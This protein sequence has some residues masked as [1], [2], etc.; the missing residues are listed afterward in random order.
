[1]KTLNEKLAFAADDRL[2]RQ[3]EWGQEKRGLLEE[4]EKWTARAEEAEV[5]RVSELAAE[6]ARNEET[7]KREVAICRK[8]QQDK[9]E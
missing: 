4:V 8:D 5:R 7:V 2:A 6:R 1:M 9:E 3:E